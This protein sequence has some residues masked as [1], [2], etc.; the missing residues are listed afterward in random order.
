MS[1]QSPDTGVHEQLARAVISGLLPDRAHEQAEKLLTRLETP[2]RIAL[3]GM[4]Q[5]GKSTILN[6]LIGETVMREEY[7]FPTC[8]FVHGRIA[9]AICTLPD[10]S[11]TA[12][13]GVDPKAI[14]ALSPAFVEIRLPLPSL[15]KIS[16]LEVVAPADPNALHRASQWASKRC[17]IA[18]WCT[19][20]FNADEQRIWSQMPD[21]LK[22]H[23]LLLLTRF[24]LLQAQGIFDDVRA[25]VK[26]AAVGEFNKII[27]I[28]G[29]AALA[30]RG[31]DGNVNK[32]ALRDSGG[33]ALISAVLK[34]FDAGRR[35]ALDL[36]EVLLLQNEDTLQNLDEV[37]ALGEEQEDYGATQAVVAA[38]AEP[39]PET[40]PEPEDE[41]LTV[42]DTS[43]P[44]PVKAAKPAPAPARP[45][46]TP[47][48]PKISAAEAEKV[49]VGIARL[50][51]IAARRAEEGLQAPAVAEVLPDTRAA[52]E[53]VIAQLE[54]RT[55]ALAGE[56]ESLGD[57]APSAIIKQAVDDLNWL[58]DYL[59]S[60][61]DDADPALLRARDTAFDAADLVQLMQM[62]KR[63]SAA[64]EALSLMLQV[65]RELQADLAA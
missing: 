10:G 41:P 34:Q 38:P 64:I 53:H 56:V 12:L 42:A 36:A 46:P 49:N 13:E 1:N 16:V 43:S 28:A 65:K 40:E 59:N 35:T 23:A 24:D 60:N 26:T 63:D 27:P 54:E 15:K 30:A 51:D 55:S 37:L 57:G 58:C 5:S 31:E 2:V 33:M 62:E 45:R 18:I 25:T 29:P 22:D 3:L 6:L 52:Y 20:G 17:D 32:V 19:G 39:E 7:R 47:A 50:R 21:A 44:E 11:K 61:G 8:Q 4:P 9:Q 14:A 48:S